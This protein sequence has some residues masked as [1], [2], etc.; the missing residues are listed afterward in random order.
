MVYL[1]VL[2]GCQGSSEQFGDI[3]KEKEMFNV[4]S[5]GFLCLAIV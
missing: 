4:R 3:L 1:M 5:R 2:V